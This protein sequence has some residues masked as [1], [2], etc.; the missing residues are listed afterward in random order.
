MVKIQTITQTPKPNTIMSIDASTNSMAFAVFSD[1]TLT[2]YGKINFKGSTPYDKVVDAAK[3][4]RAFIALYP[5]IEAIVIEHTVF[6]NSPK[7]AADL[8][9]V[10]GGLLG[11]AGVPL[12][13]S[14][15]PI[16]WQNYMGNKKPTKEELLKIKADNPGKSDSWIKTSIREVRK[17]RTMKIIGIIYDK[18]VTDND[19]AD[20]IG[21]G[22]YAVNNWERL[23]K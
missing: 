4:V 9:L 20:A 17:Q 16:T 21:V 22:H 11:A 8:A 12:I 23:T 1:D 7:T 13:R 19:V 6:M 18:I 2:S 15:A 5:E 3:K 14:V 10:Q